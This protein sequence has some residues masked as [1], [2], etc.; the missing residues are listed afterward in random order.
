MELRH[1][2]LAAHDER[3]AECFR[4]LPR[5]I[6]ENNAKELLQTRGFV[7]SK[8]AAKRLREYLRD[9][10]QFELRSARLVQQR[11]KQREDAELQR[12]RNKHECEP[13]SEL[14]SSRAVIDGNWR[15]GEPCTEAR[16]QTRPIAEWV[17]HLR[18][19]DWDERWVNSFE[20]GG[21]GV[22]VDQCVPPMVDIEARR[23]A[24]PKVNAATP[25]DSDAESAA[26]KL[27]GVGCGGTRLR[28]P[29][30]ARC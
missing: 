7:L 17:Q 19:P 26:L 27:V 24:A 1:I 6:T 8:G 25:P 20:C 22:Q 4:A 9:P 10:E 5:P 29:A 13:L 30:V 15:P 16:P 14:Q 28:E 21:A 2:T 11:A 23:F 3:L 18:A 12:Y